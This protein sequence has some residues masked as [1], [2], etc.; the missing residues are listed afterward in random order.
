[1][2][3]RSL[4]AKRILALR[5]K[6]KELAA[7]NRAN[8]EELVRQDSEIAQLRKLS[9]RLLNDRFRAEAN[10]VRK[11]KDRLS[12]ANHPALDM[13]WDNRSIML[14]A[15]L[16]ATGWEPERVV[17]AGML[18]IPSWFEAICKFSG[19]TDSLVQIFDFLGIRI[20]FDIRRFTLPCDWDEDMCLLFCSTIRNHHV[21]N[22]CTILENYG[23]WYNSL[24]LAGWNMTTLMH[25]QYSNIPWQLVL[26][27]PRWTS[28]EVCFNGMIDAIKK[29]SLHSGYFYYIAKYQKL[30]EHQVNSMA[31]VMG[32]KKPS[33]LPQ[34]TFLKEN[35]PTSEIAL[36]NLYKSASTRQ[37]IFNIIRFPPH[38]RYRFARSRDTKSLG[39]RV[40]SQ[41]G[42]SNEQMLELITCEW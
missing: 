17:D 41:I 16:D 24:R 8:I 13:I 28:S 38:M 11:E 33:S 19:R 18:A 9:E 5:Q 6:A 32:E 12:M 10:I 14:D 2:D 25:T 36:E 23:F 27:N 34:R 40:G 3:A 7:V 1:M 37:G 20:P 31:E 4:V 22:A 42:L 39:I 29:G 35:F 26:S 15:M 30:N 21:S